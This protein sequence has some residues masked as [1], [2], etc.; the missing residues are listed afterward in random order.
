[1]LVILPPD[2]LLPSR[3][4]ESDEATSA[5]LHILTKQ[6]N[7]ERTYRNTL[8]FLAAKT[9][10]DPR[11]ERFRLQSIWRGSLLSQGERRIENLEG[12]RYKQARSKPREKQV[13]RSVALIP[14]AY[15]WAIAPKQLRR[16]TY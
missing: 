4:S 2:K 9:D 12:E 11:P 6:A 16:T 8:L 14:K 10:A 5:V 15:R 13:S 1:M 7:R 3:S